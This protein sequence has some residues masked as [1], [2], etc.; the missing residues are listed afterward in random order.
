[1]GDDNGY[2]IIFGLGLLIGFIVTAFLFG[3]IGPDVKKFKQ[4]AIERNFAEFNCK[5]GEW[6]WI[7][8]TKG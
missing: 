1:M 3:T 7:E 5:T 6:Q 4:E 2:G 8:N